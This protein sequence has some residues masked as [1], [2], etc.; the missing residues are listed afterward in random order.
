MR[1]RLPPAEPP[2]RIGSDLLGRER[3]GRPRGLVPR[4]GVR[5]GWRGGGL[6]MRGSDARGSD[7]RGPPGLD[8]LTH[9]VETGVF[10]VYTLVEAITL[11]SFLV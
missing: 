1:A 5:G 3:R 9:Q 8:W 10:P 7:A 2:S 4:G 6:E 11:S